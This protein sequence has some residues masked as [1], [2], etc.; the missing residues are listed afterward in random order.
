M[1]LRIF[2]IP[3]QLV[4]GPGTTEDQIAFRRAPSWAGKSGEELAAALSGPQVRAL[5]EMAGWAETNLEGVTG[6]TTL[7]GRPVPRSAARMREQF[8]G[9]DF[10]GMSTQELKEARKAKRTS[11]DDLQSAA[12]EIGKL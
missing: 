1:L 4:V 10:G 6:V 5:V 7:D 2:G 3:V 9:A 11:I 12:R 8:D